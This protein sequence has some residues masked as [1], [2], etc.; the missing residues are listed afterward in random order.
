VRKF[1][2]KYILNFAYFVR[3]NILSSVDAGFTQLLCFHS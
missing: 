2:K 3:I 1:A